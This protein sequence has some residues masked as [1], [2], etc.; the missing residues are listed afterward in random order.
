MQETM[1]K[2]I[3][4]IAFVFV[5]MLCIG[6]QIYKA[7]YFIDSDPGFGLATPIPITTPANDV[8]LSFDVNTSELAQGFHMMILRARDNLGHWSNTYQQIFYVFKVQSVTESKITKAEYFID[9]DPGFGLA[10][11][12]PVNIPADNLSLSFDVDASGL[13]QDFHMMV[14]RTCDE[15]G[16]WG[17][18]R[19]QVFYV[20]KSIPSVIANVTG[21]EYFIDNDPGFGN[22]TPVDVTIPG[23]N[24][25]ADFIV[26][27]SGVSLGD[28]ILYLRSKDEI[29]RWS[30]TYIHAFSI[31]ATG[32]GEMEVKPWLRIYPNPNEGNFIIDFADLQSRTIKITINDLNGRTVYSNELHGENIPVSINLHAGIYMLKIEAGNQFFKQKLVINR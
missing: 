18:T 16:R 19:Q 14:L 28:H 21:I 13:T 15:L 8:S 4:S 10:T 20:F 9:S 23:D 2:L 26:N 30:H 22:G 3:L 32:I 7:E 11:P 17:T 24:V 31:F 25:T 12:I 5:A 6:Q 1:K 29:K 27:L